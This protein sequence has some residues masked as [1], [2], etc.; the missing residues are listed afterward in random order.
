MKLTDREQLLVALGAAMG[1]N[2]IPCIESILPKAR[3]VGVPDAALLAAVDLAEAVRRK[4]ARK[5]LDTAR[6]QLT[7]KTAEPEAGPCPLAAIGAPATDEACC[8]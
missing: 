2:C 8:G 6:E 5:V 4:P 3:R 7:G 1:S